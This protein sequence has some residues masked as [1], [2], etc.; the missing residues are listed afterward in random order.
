M[1]TNSRAH[2]SSNTSALS[3]VSL[4]CGIVGFFTFGIV[5][6]PVALITGWI[7]MGKRF[8]SGNVPA[9]IGFILGLII[10]VLAIVALIGGAAVYGMSI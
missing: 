7:A 3:W 9:M 1:A 6:G 4:I 5:L 2:S 8:N 10:T